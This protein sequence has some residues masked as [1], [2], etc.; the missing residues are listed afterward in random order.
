MELNADFKELKNTIEL[1]ADKR[2]FIGTDGREY[3]ID[4]DGMIQINDTPRILAPIKLNQ[5]SSLIDFLE[6]EG[7]DNKSFIQVV[8]PTRVEVWGSLARTGTPQGD[9]P[10]YAVVNAITDDIDFNN[11]ML[12]GDMIIMLQQKF[13][14]TDD[15]AA[16]LQLVG[17]LQDSDVKTQTDD[18]VSQQ[19]TIKSG[20]ASVS[21]AKVPNPVEL[22]PYRTFQEITQPV[23]KFIF[24]MREGM[25]SAL[26]EADGNQWQ[27]EAKQAIKQYLTEEQAK[28]FDG[29]VKLPVLA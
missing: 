10:L 23:S 25:Q 18:G 2:H 12:Q 16:L 22:A 4:G 1:A 7:T 17:N 6:V 19:V 5:L 13:T 11:F 14:A 8:S 15:R 9:R 29:E 28:V 27:V 26:F 3:F 20:V 21:E 24:R